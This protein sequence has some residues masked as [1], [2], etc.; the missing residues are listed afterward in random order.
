MRFWACGSACPDST[1]SRSSSSSRTGPLICIGKQKRQ[2][3][4]EDTKGLDST[5]IDIYLNIACSGHVH[6]LRVRGDGSPG[7][8]WAW[9]E[10]ANRDQTQPNRTTT[11]SFPKARIC[12][13]Q[14][15]SVQLPISA[16]PGDCAGY[17]RGVFDEGEL[18][19]TWFGPPR[20]GCFVLGGIWIAISVL[21][22]SARSFPI[23]ECGMRV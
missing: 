20:S 11:P 2:Y 14:H 10:A 8:R 16:D 1:R 23:E 12:C 15:P 18:Q 3:H 7:W 21:D 19:G 22:G 17:Y 6:A 4:D 13:V 5:T 9:P